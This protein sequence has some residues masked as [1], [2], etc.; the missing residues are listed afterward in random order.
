MCILF[1][2][3]LEIF[4]KPDLVLSSRKSS[5]VK[6]INFVLKKTLGK[7]SHVSCFP[8]VLPLSSLEWIELTLMREV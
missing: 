2:V 5:S 6:F 3:E 7:N 8:S 1:L 4:A